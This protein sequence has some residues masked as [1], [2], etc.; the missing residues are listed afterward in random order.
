MG[1][2][3]SNNKCFNCCGCCT[4]AGM[5]VCKRSARAYTYQQAPLALQVCPASSPS[6][7]AWLNAQNVKLVQNS[8]FLR[9]LETAAQDGGVRVVHTHAHARGVAL[10]SSNLTS[11]S[12]SLYRGILSA[13]QANQCL[14]I[15]SVVS[16][17]PA[18]DG[19]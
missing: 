15:T 2:W 13:M 19:S 8:L 12:A 5:H 18:R 3:R 6:A 10:L 1:G 11:S 9:F 7:A 4:A 14:Q 17:P 16:K